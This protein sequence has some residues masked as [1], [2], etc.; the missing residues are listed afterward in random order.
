MPWHFL[1]LSSGICPL[2]VKW[3]QLGDWV[4][5]PGLEREREVGT[6][7]REKVCLRLEWE[8]RG[9]GSLRGG[10]SGYG[11]EERSDGSQNRE[12]QGMVET[13]SEV[14]REQAEG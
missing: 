4:L 7:T 14:G 6:S 1:F 2:F 8:D 11:R 13:E 10:Q 3:G 9:E 5:G 12:G